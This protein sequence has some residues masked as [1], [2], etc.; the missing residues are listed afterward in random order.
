MR[1]LEMRKLE[2]RKLEYKKSYGDRFFL[3]V[4]ES[5]KD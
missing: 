1:K 3:F 2:M 4:N 5:Y